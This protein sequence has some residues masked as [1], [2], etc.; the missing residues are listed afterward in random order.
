MRSGDCYLREPKKASELFLFFDKESCTTSAPSFVPLAPRG[1]L[2]RF[3]GHRATCF[4]SARHVSLRHQT[5]LIPQTQRPDH[6]PP[7]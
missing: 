6:F 7:L 5:L 2:A 4:L 3:K 1:F